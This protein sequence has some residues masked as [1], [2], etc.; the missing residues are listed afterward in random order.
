MPLFICRWQNGDFSAVNAASRDEAMELLD[1]V[2]NADVADLFTTKNFMVHFQLK[3][4]ADNVEDI[5][6][7]ELEGFGDETYDMLLERVYP[8]Y[9]KMSAKVVDDLAS[10]GDVPKEQH[11]T[12]LKTLSEALV[13][14]RMRKWDSKKPKLSDDQDVAALQKLADVPKPMAEQVVKERRRRAITEMPSHSD[15]VQ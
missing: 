15:K 6:P 5:V 13:T 3:T 14:E 8:V 9:C 7:V 2:G 1:E 11:E 12:A 4:E 10:S